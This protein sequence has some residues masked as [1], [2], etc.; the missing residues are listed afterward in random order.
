MEI[1]PTVLEDLEGPFVHPFKHKEESLWIILVET[2]GILGCFF[3][4]AAKATL[5]ECR[6]VAQ[7]GTWCCVQFLVRT[8]ID[9]DGSSLHQSRPGSAC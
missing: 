6:V 9:L 4:L 7:Q 5:E 3:E 2:N 8:N 1:P